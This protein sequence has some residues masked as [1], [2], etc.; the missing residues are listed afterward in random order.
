MYYLRPAF[1]VGPCRVI[2]PTYLPTYK[3]DSPVKE[4][5]RTAGFS[6]KVYGGANLE[7]GRELYTIWKDNDREKSSRRSERAIHYRGIAIGAFCLLTLR[8]I[9]EV[10]HIY[11][12]PYTTRIR[13]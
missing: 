5:I 3:D 9:L 10:M 1:P 2:L 6:R 4:N 13:S 8:L 12:T 11:F 7:C